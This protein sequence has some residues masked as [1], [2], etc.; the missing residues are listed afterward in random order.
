MPLDVAFNATTPDNGAVRE[1][2]SLGLPRSADS[3]ELLSYPAVATAEVLALYGID[4]SSI[5]P[6]SDVLTS[7]DDTN[8][9]VLLDF[10]ASNRRG[11]PQRATTQHVALPPYTAAP[12]SLLTESVM[13]RHGWVPARAGWMVESVQALT[14]T[15]IAA[16]RAAAATAGLGVDTRSTQDALAALRRIAV[17]VGAGLALAIL[18]MTIGLMRGEAQRDLRTLTATGATSRTRRALAASTSGALAGL[19]LVIGVGGAYLAVVA[20]YRTD[21]DRLVPIPVGPILALAVG[22]PLTATAVGWLLAG[23]EP[24]AFARQSLD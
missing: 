13:E 19:G 14:A 7:R 16:A 4:Q 9:L 8:Q 5:D 20:A 15:Q 22:L 1:P 10:G 24:T 12:Q 17:L 18:A 21:L 3:L 2:I 6:S 23:R 11:A